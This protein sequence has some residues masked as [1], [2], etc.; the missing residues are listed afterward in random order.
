MPNIDLLQRQTANLENYVGLISEHIIIMHFSL[1]AEI[2]HVTDAYT[3]S[4]GYPTSDLIGQSVDKNLYSPS[5]P[6]TPVWTILEESGLFEGELELPNSDGDSFWLLTKIIQEID[7]E[8]KHVGYIAVSQDI[9]A[10]KLFEEQQQQLLSQ[11]RHALMGEM[12]SMIAHQWRQPLSTMSAISANLMLDLKLGSLKEESIE[13]ELIK[14]EQ[15]IAHLSQ[16]ITDFNDFF[17]SDKLKQKS[18]LSQVIYEAIKLI[19]FRL[20]SINVVTE[21]DMLEPIEIY[22][23]ELLQVLI[24]IINNAIDALVESKVEKPTLTL[25][26][27]QKR[28]DDP[29]YLSIINNGDP[30]DKKVLPHIF[31]PYFSTKK[32]N[33]TGL[34]LYIVKTIIDKHL[35][36]EISAKNLDDGCAFVIKL[37]GKNARRHY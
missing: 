13:D 12:I 3:K 2:T 15:I 18:D 24:N 25:S 14:F 33:G 23:N 28:E 11:S 4:F 19:D 27:K 1:D 10:K 35:D 16:T 7:T 5:H 6:D 30:I 26:L 34:G 37:G 31:E 29:I 8:G 21:L 20:K 36:G 17:K 9:T 22:P 32:K